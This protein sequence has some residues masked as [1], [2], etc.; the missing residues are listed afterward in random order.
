[1]SAVKI[2]N[3][4]WRLL[5][6]FVGTKMYYR[7]DNITYD[8]GHRILKQTPFKQLDPEKA[9][10]V[11]W[12]C[13]TRPETNNMS[14]F[15]IFFS[16]LFA[17]VNRPHSIKTSCEQSENFFETLANTRVIL[18]KAGLQWKATNA[19]RKAYSIQNSIEN[20]GSWEDLWE[21][22]NIF[23]SW[24]N[25]WRS[26]KHGRTSTTSNQFKSQQFSWYFRWSSFLESLKKFGWIS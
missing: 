17:N 7:T 25:A 18:Q 24:K 8:H 11:I 5:Y 2:K 15:R 12:S 13:V 6:A 14:G 21:S 10:G 4:G 16:L 22:K 23:K 20:C 26:Q 9:K 19:I 3:V 1:M